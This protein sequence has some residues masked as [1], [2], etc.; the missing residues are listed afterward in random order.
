M[1]L[2]QSILEE[3]DGGRADGGNRRTSSTIRTMDLI[4]AE[5]IQ[6][7]AM[8]VR[9]Q[10]RRPRISRLPPSRRR[11]N[12]A[13]SMGDSAKQNKVQE[14]LDAVLREFYN[15]DAEEDDI[16]INSRKALLKVSLS[17]YSCIIAC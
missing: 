2:P 9:F 10:P 12:F 8:H 15:A 7:S 14:N 6:K 5:G 1:E 16:K 11:S 3:I 4:A 17:R 13:P